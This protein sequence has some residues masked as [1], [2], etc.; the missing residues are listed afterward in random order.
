MRDALKRLA[1][2][3]TDDARL[4]NAVQ[5]ADGA[6]GKALQLVQQPQDAL[7]ADA[8][9]LLQLCGEEQWLRVADSLEELVRERLGGGRDYGTAERVCTYAMYLVRDAFLSSTAGAGNYFPQSAPIGIP[10]DPERVEAIVQSLQ[11]AA[12][13]VRARGNMLLV[14]ATC[15]SEIKDSI[16]E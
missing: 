11:R 3:G 2:V 14:L 13:G 6:L 7:L 1:D 8:A 12:S 15:I 16:Y 5:C 10:R 9:L 4:E